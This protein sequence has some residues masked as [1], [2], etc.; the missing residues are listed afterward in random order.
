MSSM[1]SGGKPVFA[2]RLRKAVSPQSVTICGLGQTGGGD[3]LPALFGNIDMCARRGIQRAADRHAEVNL[4]L[5]VGRVGRIARDVS[6]RT[7]QRR[8]ES[9]GG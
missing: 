2:A 1:R 4:P 9:I 7:A 5:G 8:A 6:V 3:K